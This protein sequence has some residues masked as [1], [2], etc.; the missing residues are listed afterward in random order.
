MFPSR[1]K[2]Q[3]Q[4]LEREKRAKK[5]A[6]SKVNSGGEAPPIGQPDHTE[7][8][9]VSSDQSQ[10]RGTV[11]SHLDLATAVE[12]VDRFHQG[13]SSTSGTVE[14]PTRSR[15]PIVNVRKRDWRGDTPL[16]PPRSVDSLVQQF[17]PGTVVKIS[18]FLSVNPITTSGVVAQVGRV[19]PPVIL[20]LPLIAQPTQ[21]QPIRMATRLKYTKFYGRKQDADDW[22]TEFLD[23]AVTNA[24]DTPASLLRIF[25]GL[26][27]R[28]L[29]TGSIMI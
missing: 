20:P 17:S 23:T 12:K 6:D 28:M 29:C 27:K 11:S 16:S 15:P 24:E 22:M 13:E 2:L 5:R 21:V 9:Q 7:G 4:K 26:M 14:K 8:I 25:P 19:N 18:S 10:E 3:E 1:E